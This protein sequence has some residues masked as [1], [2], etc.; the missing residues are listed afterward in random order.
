M[1]ARSRSTR[2]SASAFSTPT[3]RNE[4]EAAFEDDL[5]SCRELNLAEWRRR[6]LYRR[7]L[8]RIAYMLH[9]QL[10]DGTPRRFLT[11]SA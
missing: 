7:V 8:E 2:R 9:D 1:T 6:P 5:K 10:V 4:L 11:P 3:L